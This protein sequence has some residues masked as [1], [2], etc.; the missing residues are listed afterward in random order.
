MYVRI[1]LEWRDDPADAT[2][3]SVIED[4]G[5]RLLIRPVEWAHGDIVP[6]ELVRRD[7]VEAA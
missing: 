1:K 5:D 4:N 3:Y 7:M 2:V 6:V